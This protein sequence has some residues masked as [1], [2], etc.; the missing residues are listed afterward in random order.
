MIFFY[1]EHGEQKQFSVA[2]DPVTIGRSSSADIQIDDTN[3][4]REHCVISYR[5]GKHNITD[6]K[7]KNGTYVNGNKTGHAVLAIGDKIEIGTTVIMV[8]DAKGKGPSTLI[9][10]IQHEMQDEGKGYGTILREIVK[11]A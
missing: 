3:I 5:E 1:D 7:S 9:R 6:L 2:A 11:D 10:E 4:S 8:Q